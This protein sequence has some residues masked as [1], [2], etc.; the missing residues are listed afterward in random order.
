MKQR[1][2]ELDALRGLCVAGMVA[3]H[4]VFDLVS[5]FGV[6]DWEYNTLFTFIMNW[7]GVLFLL[8]SGICATLGTRSVRRGIIVFACGMLI[9]A[10][11]V[12]MYLLHMANRIIIIYFGVLHCLGICMMLWYF[13]KRLSAKVLGILGAVMAAVGLWL[14]TIT[15]DFP[16]LIWLGLTTPTFATADYFPLFPYLGFFLLGACI[17]R[18]VYRGQKTLLPQ[19]NTQ[20]ALIRFFTFCGKHSLII[21]LLHQPVLAVVIGIIAQF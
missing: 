10:V 3:V 15:V 5:L 18:T 21:Y 11:T 17:G 12:G 13:L 9:T 2:W 8:I 7:G 14:K 19:V 16:W 6:V 20:T 1:I 4:F